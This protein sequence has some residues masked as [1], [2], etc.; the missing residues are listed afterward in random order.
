MHL[1]VSQCDI[2]Q[3]NI[4]ITYPEPSQTSKIEFFAKIVKGFQPLTIFPRIRRI[5]VNMI[6][7][8]LFANIITMLAEMSFTI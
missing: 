3:R 6:T 8:I 4:N 5:I 2:A 1:F 7:C